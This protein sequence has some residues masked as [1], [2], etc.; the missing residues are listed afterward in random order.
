M[1]M[2]VVN[3]YATIDMRLGYATAAVPV[4]MPWLPYE[5]DNF[6]D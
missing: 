1:L 5:K 3:T 4:P 6:L 2:L